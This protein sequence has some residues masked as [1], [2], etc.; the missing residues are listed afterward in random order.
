MYGALSYTGTGAPDT[1]V[2]VSAPAQVKTGV[3]SSVAFAVRVIG[4]DGV[5]PAA[6]ASVQFGAQGVAATFA[7]CGAA[8]CVLTTDANGLAQTVFTG[9]AAGTLTLTAIEMSGG[10]SVQAAVLV[11]DPVRGMTSATAPRYLAAGARASWSVSVRATEDGVGRSGVSVAWTPGAGLT[12]GS[13]SSVTD[14]AGAASV[15]VSTVGLAG[16]TQASVSGCAWVGVCA[17]AV[18]FGVDP[19]QWSAGIVSGAGQS[20]TASGKLAG[21]T[22]QVT[23]AAG[24][25]LQGATVIVY[26]TVDGWEGPCA[27]K[28]RCAAAP[29]LASS[30][31]TL[32]TDAN[33]LVT[34]TPLEVPGVASVVHIA[35][36]TGTQGFVSLSLT[37]TP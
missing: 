28:G 29:V 7:S 33:G 2:L 17:S 14:A 18:V 19:T 13:A 20:V 32:T 16:G 37:K 26:Q 3:V 4:P 6:G 35:M 1:L 10:A 12:A 21:V 34:M 22:F 24:H 25:P 15:G 5:T 23:D 8:T 36:A 9:M 30:Q 27:A 31:M 11:V